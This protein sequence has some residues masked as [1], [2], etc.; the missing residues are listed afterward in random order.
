M[1]RLFDLLRRF[2][3]IKQ[4]IIVSLTIA[5]CVLFMGTAWTDGLERVAGGSS[6]S[7]NQPVQV[8]NPL[9]AQGTYN[10]QTYSV[11]QGSSH[12]QY[13]SNAGTPVTIKRTETDGTRTQQVT[14]TVRQVTPPST[15]TRYERPA[16]GCA[17]GTQ[18]RLQP[19][20]TATP[21]SVTMDVTR[22]DVVPAATAKGTTGPVSSASQP[23]ATATPT[24]TPS[25]TVASGGFDYARHSPGNAN[26]FYGSMADAGQRSD[27]VD[28]Q[29]LDGGIGDY[30]GSDAENY[31]KNIEH[32]ARS[33]EQFQGRGG[34]THIEVFDSNTKKTIWLVNG[35]NGFYAQEAREGGAVLDKVGLSTS[36]L[37]ART[38]NWVS[39]N[40]QVISQWAS[41]ANE[42]YSIGGVDSLRG[43]FGSAA[44]DPLHALETRAQEAVAGP[45]SNPLTKALADAQPEPVATPFERMQTARTMY[46]SAMMES[47]GGL[48]ADGIES[49]RQVAFQ[50]E[51][52][53]LEERYNTLDSNDAINADNQR[54]FSR[55]VETLRQRYGY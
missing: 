43:Y 32:G 34:L 6:Q 15:Q 22:V 49:A 54:A 21:A 14:Y 3:V 7:N 44:S 45:A 37:Y 26:D 1:I 50:A 46:D 28:G 17:T 52:Q 23:A 35:A 33:F 16:G 13:Q 31:R 12:T 20:T 9:P 5:L 40:G 10:N 18:C 38:A 29:I 27:I 11:P 36:G 30:H 55:A 39:E 41:A 19:V 51:Y 47:H 48:Q 4:T 42:R 2:R 53:A 25:Q 24:A 8:S